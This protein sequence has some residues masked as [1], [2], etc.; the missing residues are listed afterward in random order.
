MSLA[1]CGCAK[2]ETVSP[3]NFTHL[4]PG[5]GDKYR[6][7]TKTGLAF[8]ATSFAVEDSMFVVREVRPRDKSEYQTIP[9]VPFSV[10]I[11]QIDRVERVT[12]NTT[13][14][15]LVLTAVASLIGGALF[16]V[17]NSIPY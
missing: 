12:T 15:I 8:T 6:V 17:W 1:L 7:T 13:R 14:S 5:T 3:S 2:Y 16:W 4:E 9:K 10:P 11:T